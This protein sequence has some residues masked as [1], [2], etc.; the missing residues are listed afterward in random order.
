ML[1]WLVIPV[2]VHGR[3]GCH[4]GRGWQRVARLDQVMSRWDPRDRRT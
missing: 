2:D 4:Y 3:D 1:Y